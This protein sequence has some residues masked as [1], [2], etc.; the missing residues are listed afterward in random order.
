MYTFLSLFLNIYSGEK[1]RVQA[2]V[3]QREGETQNTRQAPGS[4]QSAQGPRWGSN[5]TSS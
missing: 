5:S 1:E 3:G 2:G 4:E